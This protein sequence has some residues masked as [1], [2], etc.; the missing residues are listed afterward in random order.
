MARRKSTVQKSVE[1]TLKKTHGLTIFFVALFFV[2]GAVGGW[3]GYG[4]VTKNDAFEI[5]GEKKITIELNGTYEEQGCKVVAWGKD[6]TSKL[7]IDSDLDTTKEGTYFV[8]YTVENF[9]YK[10]VQKVR[11][12][13]VVNPS[14]GV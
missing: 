1:K 4:L 12:V 2:I 7:K 6:E 3:F 9:K 5:I 8:V 11:V 14:A 13:T 10:S